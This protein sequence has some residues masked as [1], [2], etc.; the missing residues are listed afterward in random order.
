L[1]TFIKIV[2]FPVAFNIYQDG[3]KGA[4][5]EIYSDNP[6]PAPAPFAIFSDEG[7]SEPASV[8]FAIFADEPKPMPKP[9]SIFSDQDQSGKHIDLQYFLDHY[10][11]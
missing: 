6:K 1:S 11:L 9:F 7:N 8:P 2:I 4:G 5:F 10:V 3:M